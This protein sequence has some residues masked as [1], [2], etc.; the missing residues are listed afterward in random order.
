MKYLS[1]LFFFFFPRES[2][3]SADKGFVCSRLLCELLEMSLEAGC[4]KEPGSFHIEGSC[5]GIGHSCA[6][7]TPNRA[8][9]PKAFV[10]HCEGDTAPISYK[11][12]CGAALFPPSSHTYTHTPPLPR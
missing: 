8:T 12:D 10:P 9:S 4:W 7:L 3:E 1:F 2:L 5:V 6:A 11:V